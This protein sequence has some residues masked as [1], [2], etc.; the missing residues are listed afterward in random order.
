MLIEFPLLFFLDDQLSMVF[1][2]RSIV[3]GIFFFQTIILRIALFYYKKGLLVFTDFLHFTPYP[4]GYNIFRIVPKKL[5]CP[6]QDS[7]KKTGVPTSGFRFF[8][9]LLQLL[10]HHSSKAPIGSYIIALYYVGTGMGNGYCSIFQLQYCHAIG[11]L[12]MNFSTL[13]CI[14][15][16]QP[17][18]VYNHSL[19]Y[20]L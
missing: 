6:P 20:N 14:L 7:A 15:I 17:Y 12:F 5:A 18:T 10:L 3:N 19:I 4:T 16:T 8:Y 9:I 13:H 1:S 11:R 2:W